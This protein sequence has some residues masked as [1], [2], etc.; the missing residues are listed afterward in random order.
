MSLILKNC[1]WVW[2]ETYFL[3]PITCGGR[4]AQRLASLATQH[5]F[6]LSGLCRPFS[7]VQSSHVKG[8]YL[9]KM[10]GRSGPGLPVIRYTDNRHVGCSHCLTLTT[11]PSTG[12]IVESWPLLVVSSGHT[13]HD[14]QFLTWKVSNLN[15]KSKPKLEKVWENDRWCDLPKTMQC[16]WQNQNWVSGVCCS[17]DCNGLTGRIP[18]SQD[19][20]WISLLVLLCSHRL[21]MNYFVYGL[22]VFLHCIACAM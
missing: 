10:K 14:I 9:K 22:R 20:S 13:S 6:V 15:G 16:W 4:E 12:A 17:G 18:Y 1:E 11:I 5:H 3:L 7:C 19:C 8:N 2:S 21:G